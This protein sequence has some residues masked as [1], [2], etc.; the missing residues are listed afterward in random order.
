MSSEPAS[1]EE[2][3][4][5]PEGA[6]SRERS[7][8]AFP[9][10]DLN[11]AILVARNVLDFGGA[12]TND[13]LAPRLGYSS[14]DNGAFRTRVGAARHFGLVT[15]S[16]DTLTI[17]NPGRE[18]VDPTIE[19]RA[20][21]TAFL[22]VALYQKVYTDHKGFMLP[23]PAG[24]ELKFVEY[25]VAAKQKDK[26]RQAFMR[27]AEQAGFFQQGRD[28]LVV[29][30]L[31]V[32][33]VAQ[34]PPTPAD[35]RKDSGGSGGGGGDMHPFI[36]GLVDTLP[37]PGHPWSDAERDEWLLAAKSIF[38]L[39]YKPNRLALAAG[40]TTNQPIPAEQAAV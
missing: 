35:Q 9:Y 32:G 16:K 3:Q 36:R 23:P 25:G 19:A 20:R 27:S 7:T 22:N 37:A 1:I 21:V 13:Q 33:H 2:A 15:T 18:I 40:G 6:S 38:A 31:P 8:I 24:L 26:A 34:P 5:S 17:T 11:D 10:D 29:P 4:E 30:A 39:I 28:R 12:C 14:V